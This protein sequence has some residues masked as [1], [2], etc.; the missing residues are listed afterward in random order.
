M[1]KYTMVIGM[2]CLANSW[3]VLLMTLILLSGT[4]VGREVEY[5]DRE[6]QIYI[7][8]GEPTQVSF[9]GEVVG[10]YKKKLSAL[11][12]ERRGNALILFANE[13]LTAAGETLIVHLKDGRSYSLRAVLAEGPGQR[14]DVV[15]IDDKR[16]GVP[17]ETVDELTLRQKYPQAPADSV[18]GLMREMVLAVEFGKAA[19]TGYR[20]SSRY[21]G[22]VILNDGTL[23]AKIDRIFIGPKLWGYVIKAENMLNQTQQLNP[24]AFRVHGTR[25][26]SANI[27]E[28]APKPLTAEQEAARRDTAT[29]YVVTRAK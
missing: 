4:A 2:K 23:E 27:W 17:G 21:Q 5:K 12:V 1:N 28:L 14:D 8:S 25:A 26:V 16:L 9:P 24:A 11:E 10:G 3:L 7:L 6:E 15:I 29:V 13:S 22:E 18:A 20:A 19:I